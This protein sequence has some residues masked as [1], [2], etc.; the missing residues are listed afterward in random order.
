MG[1]D[2]RV[3]DERKE[4]RRFCTG[5]IDVRI[6][7]AVAGREISSAWVSLVGETKAV[8]DAEPRPW[9]GDVGRLDLR[10]RSSSS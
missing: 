9:W 3:V 8:S 4:E 7:V 2:L 10:W 5:R 6:A 1:D